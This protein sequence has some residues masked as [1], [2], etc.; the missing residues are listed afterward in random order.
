ME[1]SIIHPW[2]FLLSVGKSLA[3]SL[4]GQNCWMCLLYS[5]NHWLHLNCRAFSL[6]GQN[7]CRH[8]SEGELPSASLCGNIASCVPMMEKQPT[9]SPNKKAPPFSKLEVSTLKPCAWFLFH[10]EQIFPSPSLISCTLPLICLSHQRQSGGD[11]IQHQMKDT[12]TKKGEF[13]VAVQRQSIVCLCHSPVRR[14]R[15]R[16]TTG[17]S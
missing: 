1:A 11:I 10:Q 3:I 7:C 12:W 2:E 4:T 6:Q 5:K 13:Q 17:S 15:N 14:P 16:F 8:I 9:M